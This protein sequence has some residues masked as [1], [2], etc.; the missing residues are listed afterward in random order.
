MQPLAVLDEEST[1]HEDINLTKSTT[2]EIDIILKKEKDEEDAYS[3]PV[4]KTYEQKLADLV[5]NLIIFNLNNYTN[6]VF[7]FLIDDSCASNF[8]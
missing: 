7:C 8:N 4:G 1:D 5:R 2:N 3:V 6:Y